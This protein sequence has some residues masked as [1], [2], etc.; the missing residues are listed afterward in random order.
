MAHNFQ[1]LSFENFQM[2]IS[3]NTKRQVLTTHSRTVWLK[4][5]YKLLSIWDNDP[6]LSLLDYRNTAR[7][8]LL[9]SPAQGL[10]GRRTKTLLPTS[11]KLLEPK[12]IKRPQKQYYNRH[13]KQLSDLLP[14]Q[15]VRFQIGKQWKPAVVT[16]ISSEPRSYNIQILNGQS[17]RRNRRH[18]MPSTLIQSEQF[19][20]WLAWLWT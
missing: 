14:G 17:Y 7:S 2:I 9:G 1:M 6:Y 5:L 11:C 3:S 15:S 13:A 19:L 18:L 12:V 10:M 4:R 20:W 16:S 8:D